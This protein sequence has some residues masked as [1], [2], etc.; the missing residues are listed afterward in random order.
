MTRCTRAMSL[1]LLL[2]GCGSDGPSG[3]DTPPPRELQSPVLR[4]VAPTSLR[5]GDELTIFGAN[6][7]DEQLGEVRVSFEGVYQTTA[8]RDCQVSLEVVPTFKNQGVLT[9]EFG[10]NIPFCTE[11]EDTGSFRGIVRA[12]NVGRDGQVKETTQA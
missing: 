2:V 9:W 10:P 3:P 8:G 4:S 11:E 1:T 5:A 6:F 7:A 12:R